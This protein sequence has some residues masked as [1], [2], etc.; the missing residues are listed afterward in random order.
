MSFWKR[1]KQSSDLGSSA[2]RPFPFPAI[3][4][5]FR[6]NNQSL[7]RNGVFAVRANAGWLESLTRPYPSRY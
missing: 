2:G 3:L 4:R 1:R 7:T 6:T 5:R